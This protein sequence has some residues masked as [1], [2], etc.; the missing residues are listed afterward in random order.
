MEFQSPYC[1]LTPGCTNYREGR[2][3]GCASCNARERKEERQ[4]FTDSLKKPRAISQRSEKKAEEDAEYKLLRIDFLIEYP[5]C[6]ISIN[7][8]CNRKATQIHHTSLSA[9][10]YLNTTTWLGSCQE[11]HNIIERVLSAEVRREKGLLTD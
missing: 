11:C 3:T 10:N 2:L 6:Q 7:G 5:T 9:L 8:P 4:K 1:Q